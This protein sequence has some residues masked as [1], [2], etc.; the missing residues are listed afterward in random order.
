MNAGEDRRYNGITDN[1]E[2]VGKKT[3]TKVGRQSTDSYNSELGITKI[4]YFRYFCGTLRCATERRKSR[5]N[6][7]QLQNVFTGFGSKVKI[8]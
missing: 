7:I 8:D 4:G 3:R 5:S 1:N 6:E 2:E